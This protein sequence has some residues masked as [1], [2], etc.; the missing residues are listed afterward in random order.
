MPV[1]GTS[2]RDMEYS[3]GGSAEADAVTLL[4]TYRYAIWIVGV[5]GAAAIIG[6]NF[7]LPLSRSSPPRISR[8]CLAGT[9]HFACRETVSGGPSPAPGDNIGYLVL[10]SE[11][12]VLNDQTGHYDA[13]RGPTP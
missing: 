5:P 10:W 1:D 9:G 12:G 7:A 3:T 11:N 13:G 6:N 8:S 2:W 4:T